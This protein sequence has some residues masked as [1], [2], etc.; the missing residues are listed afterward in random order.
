MQKVFNEYG[1]KISSITFFSNPFFIQPFI[2]F[3]KL[4]GKE[5]PEKIKVH[6]EISI[7]NDIDFVF[8]SKNLKKK[9]CWLRGQKMLFL[10]R[11]SENP[12]ES[13][14]RQLTKLPL[15]HEIH[16]DVANHKVRLVGHFTHPSGFG[17][18]IYY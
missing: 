16:V 11:P 8:Y 2:I 15:D 10:I 9:F 18:W 4:R 17:E 1:E 7:L 6:K 12:K 14:W 3:D 13:G 5:L